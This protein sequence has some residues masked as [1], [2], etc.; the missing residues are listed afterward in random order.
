[1][2]ENGL[3]WTERHI[4]YKQINTVLTQAVAGFAHFYA[5]SVSK[6]TF[7]A[8]LTRWPIHNL[9]DL[10]CP[11]TSL[12]ITNAGVHCHVTNFPDSFALPKPR[13]PSTI[14]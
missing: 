7:L 12:S 10:E 8:G 9:G 2:S 11:H 5:Y 3:K 14:S 13:I 1:M 4:E 6:C